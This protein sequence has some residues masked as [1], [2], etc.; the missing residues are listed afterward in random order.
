MSKK[1]IINKV[2]E[3]IILTDRNLNLLRGRR[4]I[5]VGL[6]GGADSCALLRSLL[7]ISDTFGYKISAV[8]VNHGIREEEAQRD[9]SFSENLCKKLSVDFYLETVNVPL[10][11]KETG[12]SLE[13]AARKARYGVFEKICREN[14][15]DCIATAHTASDNAETVIFNLVRGSG[16]SGICGIPAKRMLG[17]SNIEIIRPLIY[18]TRGDI[19][20][21]LQALGQGFVT[22]ST[23]LETDCTRNFLRHEIIPKLKIINPS[24]ENTVCSLVRNLAYDK[25]YLDS[26]TQGFVSNDIFKLSMLPMALKTR[27]VKKL[28]EDYSGLTMLESTHIESLICEI[29][30]CFAGEKNKSCVSLPGKVRAVICSGVLSFETD[31][32]EKK[33]KSFEY[34]IELSMGINAVP[35]GSYVLFV[36][37]N[38]NVLPDVMNY[39]ENVY[40]KYNTA[41]LYFDKIIDSLCA[42]NRRNSDVFEFKGMNRKVKKLLSKAQIS[43]FERNTIPFVTNGS[44]ILYIPYIGVADSCAFPGANKENMLQIAVYSKQ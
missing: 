19:E 18:L 25:E 42:R 34:E 21:Y 27:A 37:N 6:S 41:F 15:I 22:D 1:N 28:Y 11:S 3:K 26:I 36:T 35:Y 10:I 5:L 40:K 44:E 7:E 31:K 29:D 12:E 8:H 13:T 23:N 16:L 9:A 14:D 2:A 20:E 17:D 39:M 38:E 32:R 4:H 33:Q 24:F 43:E 30:A